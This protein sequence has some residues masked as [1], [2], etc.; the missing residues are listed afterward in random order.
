MSKG[1]TLIELVLTV[2]VLSILSAFTFSVI[3]QYSNLYATTKG[4][5]IYAEASAVLERLTRELRDAS[6]VDVPSPNPAT[7]INFKLT[8]GTPVAGWVN[9]IAPGCPSACATPPWVQYCTCTSG[10][11]TYLYR[12]QNTSQGAANQCQA[13]CPA[14]GS[15][16]SRMSRNLTS[17]GFQITC[18]AGNGTCGSA[19]PIS[20]SYSI[21]L[22]LRSDQ[23]P[24]SQS[25]TLVSRVSPR[26]YA[27]YVSGSGTGIGLD[28]DFSGG[29]CDE[30]Q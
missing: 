15:N 22:Q 21:Q 12:V 8:H 13:G 27:P 30:N 9:G 29:Y 16:V 23:T 2:I 24:N 18:Y 3:W 25:L 14:A 28:R 4:G 7:Y 10:G 17:S 11:R 5:Y 19:G 6:S 26:N 20:D 1:F